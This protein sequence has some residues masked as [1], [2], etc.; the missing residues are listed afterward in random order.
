[1]ASFLPSHPVSTALQQP[2]QSSQRVTSSLPTQ[3]RRTFLVQLKRQAQSLK[4]ATTANP[5]P[6]VSPKPA[7]LKLSNLPYFVRRT[8]SNQL[9]VY[10]VTKAGGTKQQTK[11]QK[12]EGN[13]NALRDDL[14]MYLDSNSPKSSEV[15]INRLNNHIIVKGW[16]KPEILRFLE[17]RNF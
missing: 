17:E 8:A 6:P 10:L 11:I 15:T 9:P 14:T 2:I 13:V 5:E 1:M 4:E 16:R 3:Q 7:K 12:T